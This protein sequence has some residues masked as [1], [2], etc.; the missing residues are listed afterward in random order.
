MTAIAGAFVRPSP[1]AYSAA[2]LWGALS[3]FLSPCHLGSIPLIVAY[4]N[5]G[6]NPS[7][8]KAFAYS[9]LFALGLMVML[10]AVGFATSA[11]GR[12]FGDVGET[13]RIVAALFIVIC[14][15]WLMDVPPLSRIAFSFDVKS[16]RRGMW[17]AFA[18]G[19]IYGVVLGP[20]SF[21]FLAPMLAFV[22]QAGGSEIAFGASLMALYALGH[23]A[24]IVAAGTFGDAVRAYLARKGSG[25]AAGWFKRALGAVVVFAGIALVI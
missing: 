12:L 16:Q 1:A 4:A 6:K 25:N 17:G 13:P 23:T 19:L 5:K 9:A 8:I 22:F 24:A 10:A 11:A 3:V 7:R 20:C 15:L 18:L 14:G 2:A 21:A